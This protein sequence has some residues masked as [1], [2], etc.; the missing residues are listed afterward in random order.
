MAQP[1]NL[2]EYLQAD[3]DTEERSELVYSTLLDTVFPLALVAWR[4][5]GKLLSGSAQCLFIRP[6]TTGVIGV[7]V[8]VFVCDEREY[9]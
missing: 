9:S 3:P 4:P 6:R 7:C 5:G 1:Y 8:R 2:T